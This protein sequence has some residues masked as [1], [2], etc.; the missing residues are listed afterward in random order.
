MMRTRPTNNTTQTP[1]PTKQNMSNF[2]VNVTTLEHAP[3]AATAT[4]AAAATAT[5]EPAR[6]ENTTTNETGIAV[7]MCPMTVPDGVI[8]IGRTVECGTVP[9]AVVE[10]GKVEEGEEIV[11]VSTMTKIPPT[12]AE[13]T[14]RRHLAVVAVEVATDRTIG[15][16]VIGIVRPPLRNAHGDR[17]WYDGHRHHRRNR[18]MRDRGNHRT[19]VR[20]R[21][22][23]RIRNRNRNNRRHRRR[24]TVI[25]TTTPMDTSRADPG[26]SLPAATGC[27][28]MWGWG[29][30]VGSS[31]RSI[32]IGSTDINIT[33][34]SPVNATIV[35][36]ISR[37]VGTVITVEGEGLDEIV[38]DDHS[39]A[40]PPQY[41]HQTTNKTTVTTETKQSPSK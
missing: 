23:N 28:M 34:S 14:R 22:R 6:R 35:T 18:N 19:R 32:F 12:V 16:I 5:S 13:S 17:R 36:A 9:S 10:G 39:N 27:S 38:T 1:N 40:T 20:D 30:S 37:T 21:I 3:P 4:A 33:A 31:R 8:V 11:P 29:R 24:L 15:G 41:H 2:Q 25:R 26:P 7:M